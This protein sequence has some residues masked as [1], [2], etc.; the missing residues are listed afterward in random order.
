MIRLRALPALVAALA[1][2]G[3]WT[4]Q[5]PAAD[6]RP[7]VLAITLD[8]EINPVSAS[9]VKDSVERAEDRHAAALVILLDTPGGLSTSMDD[10]VKA[11]LASNVPVIVYVSPEGARAASAGV[12]IT[13]AAD[14]AAMAPNTNIG[15][16]TPIS[17]TGDNL[18]SD[19]RRKVLND[20]EA[21]IKALAQSH[22]RN[23]EQAVLTVRE[24]TNYTADEAVQSGLVDKLAPDLPTLLEEID[25]TE[26][27][28]TKHLVFH[29]A[30]AQIVNE[31]MPFTLKLLNILINPN[32]LFLLFL[33]GIGGLGYEIF[34]PGVILPGTVGA[35][36]LVLALFGFSIVPI[37]WAGIA[38]IVFGVALL[39][40]EGFVVSGGLLGVS[41]IIA[42]SAGGL[43]LFR[44]PGSEMSVSPYVVVTIAVL[45]G[46]ALATIATKVLA[47][48]KQPVSPAAAGLAGLLGQRAVVRTPL[49]PR[50]QV[51]IDGALWE[52][53]ADDGQAGVGDTVIV[54]RVEGLTLH[55]EPT[56]P[57]QSSEGALS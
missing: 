35:V 48:R 53:E 40:A 17:S 22:G 26:T 37:N 21:R 56:G 14:L 9:F 1:A 16:A 36:S 20:A 7:L 51:F 5:S 31:D 18:D 25:G 47:A 13:M 15:S 44:T 12:Y 30:D 19:L 28:G 6:N 23:A 38:L 55:V 42:L 46:A 43:L 49:A 4:S 57:E 50:G 2:V 41:G 45:F 3:V 34:H 32:L 39:I 27:R 29:T 8:S 52:A 11:E 33:L 24:A 10:I 54:R